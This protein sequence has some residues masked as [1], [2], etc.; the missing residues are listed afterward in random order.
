MNK[1][2]KNKLK[3]KNMEGME[4]TK[5]TS[6][7]PPPPPAPLNY[8]KGLHHTYRKGPNVAGMLAYLKRTKSRVNA[9]HGEED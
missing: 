9:F 3:T 2:L 6:S 4:M 5:N 1:K 7:P 8:R